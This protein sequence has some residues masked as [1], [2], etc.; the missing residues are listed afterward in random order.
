MKY[1]W[2]QLLSHRNTCKIL[3]TV[4]LAEA[5]EVLRSDEQVILSRK[6]RIDE[7]TSEPKEETKLRLDLALKKLQTEILLLRFR[8]LKFKENI[9][10]CDSI[11]R[12]EINKRRRDI[13]LKTFLTN[14]RPIQQERN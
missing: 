10:E 12:R 4:K 5:Y 11:I 1:I 13:S 9:E 3:R 8:V 6:F 7:I 14:G 2:K